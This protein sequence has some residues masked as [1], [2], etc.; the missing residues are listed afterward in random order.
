[1]D[2]KNVLLDNMVD[3][4]AQFET[5]YANLPKAKYLNELF[6]LITHDFE[7]N[8]DSQKLYITP[9]VMMD[10]HRLYYEYFKCTSVKFLQIIKSLVNCSSRRMLEN[11]K[12]KYHQIHFRSFDENHYLDDEL[13]VAIFTEIFQYEKN[14]K[15]LLS[16]LVKKMIEYEKD[17][18]SGENKDMIILYRIKLI[19]KVLYN[20]LKI[21]N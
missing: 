12:N 18:I 13:R 20:Q 21:K 3:I 10:N 11:I 16:Y 5:R 7:L 2:I 6:L 8:I 9:Y 19:L 14:Q 15:D 1:M 4:V 17:I